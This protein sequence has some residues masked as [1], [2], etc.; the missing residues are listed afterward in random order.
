MKKYL[1]FLFALC[2]PLSSVLAVDYT[3]VDENNL[4]YEQISSLREQ[5][6]IGGYPDGSFHPYQD[7]TRAE[8]AKIALSAW[9]DTED[10]EACDREYF[11]DV[12][13]GA[14]YFPYV[15][16]AKE[17][18]IIK[19]Y[20]NNEFKPKRGIT[21]AEMAKIVVKIYYSGVEDGEGENWWLPYFQKLQ[22]EGIPLFIGARD[23]FITRGEMCYVIDTILKKQGIIPTE[24][25]TSEEEETTETG[26][27]SSEEEKILFVGGEKAEC[28]GV[29]PQE[30]YQ[31][32][33]NISDNWT[34]FSDEIEGFEWEEGYMY[35][36]VVIESPLENP[37]ADSSS[38][39][40]EL[41]EVISKEKVEDEPEAEEEN[42]GE[43]VE[44]QDEEDLLTYTS[45]AHNISFDYPEKIDGKNI[46]V[47]EDG[48]QISLGIANISDDYETCVSQRLCGEIDD[49]QYTFVDTF[50]VLSKTAEES[51]TESIKRRIEEKGYDA[52]KCLFN[53]KDENE[54]RKLT[55]D[56][57]IPPEYEEGLTEGEKR[58]QKNQELV[59][60][61]SIYAGGYGNTFFYFDEDRLGNTFLYF[62]SFGSSEREMVLESFEV[63]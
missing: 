45:E 42:I 34:L 46:E 20:A 38:I 55:I 33:E 61:C 27:V 53:V 36:L 52:N 2:L 41:L 22:A 51:I 21:Y 35:E 29:A 31:V 26:N 15:C 18:D 62:P 4:Y 50:Y 39:K 54:G 5:G 28:V 6:I 58:S 25:Q 13:K 7:L 3:D 30:C 59:E 14:W 16:F 40:T 43:G 57:R 32:K 11:D 23:H 17:N 19:G 9:Y 10:I 47:L 48:I 49:I 1:A 37:P 24:N 12:P 44:E 8:F 60:K 56:L 63:E